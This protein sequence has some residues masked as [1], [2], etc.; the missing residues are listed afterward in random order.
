MGAYNTYG[1]GYSGSSMLQKSIMQ[2][3]RIYSYPD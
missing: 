2:A 3:F 1:A